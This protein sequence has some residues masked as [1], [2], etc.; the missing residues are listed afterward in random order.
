[1]LIGSSK[2]SV[3]VVYKITKAIIEGRDEFANVVSVMKG[4]SGQEMAKNFD[5]AY[6]PGAAKYYKEAGL[7]K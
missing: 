6:H 1:V 5:M 2:T 4:I 3:D 7:L